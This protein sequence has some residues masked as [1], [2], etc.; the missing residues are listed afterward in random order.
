MHCAP[1]AYGGTQCIRAKARRRAARA[2]VWLSIS[3]PSRY[4]G[5]GPSRSVMWDGVTRVSTEMAET[6][7]AVIGSGRT[8]V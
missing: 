8:R 5:S 4:S 2:M 3:K 1:L 7:A 6:K